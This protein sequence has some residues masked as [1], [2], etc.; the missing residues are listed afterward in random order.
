METPP[1]HPRSIYKQGLL[2][3]AIEKSELGYQAVEDEPVTRFWQFYWDLAKHFAPELE[4]KAPSS[5][6][7]G[8][9]FVWFRPQGLPSNVSIVHKL[10]F[11]NVDL[12]FSGKGRNLQEL[13]ERFGKVVDPDMKIVRANESGSIRIRVPE[14]DTTIG[15]EKQEGEVKVGLN[16]AKRLLA[17]FRETGGGESSGSPL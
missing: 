15:F 1:M 3:S 10:P 4:M 9:G 17:W 11:G 12:Q 8:A 16:A 14:L 6:P 13:H 7:S 5:K 2:S